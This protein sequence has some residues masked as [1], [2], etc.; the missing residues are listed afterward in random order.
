MPF[1]SPFNSLN[2]TT[3]IR[4][5]M[6]NRTAYVRP[7][8]YTHYSVSPALMLEHLTSDW[9]NLYNVHTP[10]AMNYFHIHRVEPKCLNSETG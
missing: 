2:P 3:T 6:P 9:S 7:K 8:T 5:L 10:L 4:V 1:S